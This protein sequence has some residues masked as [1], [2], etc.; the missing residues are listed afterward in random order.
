VY[1]N[2]DEP[3]SD[4]EE[5]SDKS[6]NDSDEFDD[7]AQTKNVRFQQDESHGTHAILSNQENGSHQTTLQECVEVTVGHPTIKSR[8][9]QAVLVFD[10]CST[11][12][13]IKK[14]LCEKLGLPQQDPV[15]L[16][17]GT[18]MSSDDVNVDT[19]YTQLRIRTLNGRLLR[20]EPQSWSDYAERS[21]QS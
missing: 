19:F 2:F 5:A 12:T 21:K 10:G 3:D 18:F 4:A 7:N 15:K 9:C 14:S 8:Q 20:F 1:E 13:F 6:S 17:I 11:K 16:S